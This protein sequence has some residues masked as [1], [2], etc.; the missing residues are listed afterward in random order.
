M[1]STVRQHRR[2]DVSLLFQLQLSKNTFVQIKLSLLN[3][4]KSMVLYSFDSVLCFVSL[5][6]ADLIVTHR[7]HVLL[8]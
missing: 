8:W 6:L 3:C 2:I 1:D 4:Q 7:L 5:V